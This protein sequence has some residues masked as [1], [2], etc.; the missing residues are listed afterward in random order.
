MRLRRSQP[1]WTHFWPKPIIRISNDQTTR[2]NWY[3]RHDHLACLSGTLA[4][5]YCGHLC[6][7]LACARRDGPSYRQERN[8]T[9]LPHASAFDFALRGQRW[10]LWSVDLPCRQII[11]RGSTTISSKNCGTKYMGVTSLVGRR[12]VPTGTRSL[13]T[14]SR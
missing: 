7:D 6:S 10:N 11:G 14:N 1:I 8:Q 3:C 12:F 5:S 2:G 13:A 4:I 9:Q